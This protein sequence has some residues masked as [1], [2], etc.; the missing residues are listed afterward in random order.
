MNNKALALLLSL[1]FVPIAASAQTQP[2]PPPAAGAAPAGP[3]QMSPAQRQAHMQAFRAFAEQARN[4]HRTARANM[5]AALT[6]AHRALLARLV[7]SLAISASPDPRAVARE[8]DAALSSGERQAVL[9]AQHS[10]MTQMRA[11]HEHMMAQM[12][13]S[14][15]G[16]MRGHMGGMGTHRHGHRTPDA[17]FILLRSALPGGA[18]KLFGMGHHSARR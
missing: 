6:S 17:G 16:Q 9:N 8:L 12:P 18:P 13:S 10:E 2:P 14:H 11:L 3:M 15:A 4:L 5:L 7:G 1:A